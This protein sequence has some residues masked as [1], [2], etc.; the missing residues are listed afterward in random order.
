M[1]DL[2]AASRVRG[3]Q[4]AEVV[5]HRIAFSKTGDARLLSHRNTMDVLERAIRAA[6]LPA[7][8]TEGF[9]PHM[10]LS[11]GPALAL[12][13]ESRHE[14]FDVDGRAAFPLD[15]AE[16]INA[17][18]PA[19]VEV[20]EVRSLGIAEPS[21]AKAVK[22]ARYSVRL[23]SEEH[24]ERAT[25]ALEN[26]WRESMPALRAFALEADASGASLTFEVNLDQAAGDTATAKKVLEALLAIP[27]AEQ[28]GMSITREATLLEG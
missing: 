2:P 20:L 16:R 13:L 11:M 21:L 8:Y 15:A 26:S 9:N 4:G 19:G 14:V 12:G 27:P 3:N 6:G 10:K 7:R 5:R 24:V 18:L 17:K 22:G 1:P 28:A 25:G 23:D